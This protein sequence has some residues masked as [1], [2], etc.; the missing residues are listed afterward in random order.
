MPSN[1]LGK[2]TAW[3]LVV[4]L[5][6]FVAFWLL[7]S[8]QMLGWELWPIGRGDPGIRA[9]I[10]A[11]SGIGVGK[12]RLL[13]YGALCA[14][15][16]VG[17]L[18]LLLLLRPGRLKRTA[19]LIVALPMF[20]AL[21]VW[22]KSAHYYH[23]QGIRTFPYRLNIHAISNAEHT[24]LFLQYA[25]GRRPLIETFEAYAA[26]LDA[27]YL[28]H[29]DA[30]ATTWASPGKE[31]TK[32]FYFLNHVSALWAYGEPKGINTD[33]GC[34][35]TNTV[36]GSRAGIKEGAKGGPQPSF[37]TYWESPIGCCSDYTLFLNALLSRA[38]IENRVIELQEQPV[39][40]GHSF[41]EAKIDGRWWV[42]DA[43]TGMAINQSWP[44]SLVLSNSTP[45]DIYLFQHPGLNPA[46]KSLYR[47][48]LG[49][50]RMM[51][52]NLIATRSAEFYSYKSSYIEHGFLSKYHRP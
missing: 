20:G 6:V 34:V 7:L 27:Q 32:A 46:N 45:T 43:N 30:L 48:F 47:P 29:R 26:L 25:P 23:E 16:I 31:V 51:M 15:A 36:T 50:F 40:I 1:A 11:Y 18:Y 28:E 3:F 12:E 37:K 10:S 19:V 35:L 24:E 14:G 52:I 22:I 49:S 9:T 8:L 38:G 17:G 21:P 42:L 44:A 5:I 2:E 13:Q 4:T 33:G 41:N 39:G